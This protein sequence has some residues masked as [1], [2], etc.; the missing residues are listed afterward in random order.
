VRRRS[1]RNACA[2]A[3]LALLAG[4]VA[5]GCGGSLQT[6]AISHSALERLI[7][8]PTPVYWLGGSFAG[9]A[10]SEATRDPSGSYTVSYGNCLQGGQG[11]CVTPLRM[12]TSPDN[13]FLPVGDAPTRAA[14]IR[15]VPARV[16]QDGRTIVL[17][18][19][20]VV[21][22]IYAS[23]PALAAAAARA[24]VPIN[25]PPSASG[26]LAPPQPDSGFGATPLP[27][28][29]P[30]PLRALSEPATAAARDR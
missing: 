1:C 5:G 20:D 23:T 26:Q 18:T 28:Q 15:G 13:S 30:S 29:R 17:A 21:L 22:D 9:L 27:S 7:A 2:G 16:A 12:I 3:A 6:Q 8:S 24:A 19:G 4:A 11:I 14:S 25:R 10:A